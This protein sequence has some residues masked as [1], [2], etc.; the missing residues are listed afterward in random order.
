MACRTRG[1]IYQL[2]AKGVW[3]I[4][5]KAEGR[6]HR[7]RLIGTDGLPVANKKEAQAAANRLLVPIREEDKAERARLLMH[8]YRDAKEAAQSAEMELAN[9][10]GRVD[11]GWRMFMEC[12]RRPK[13]CRD[14]TAKDAVPMHS[15]AS[16]YK[17]IF[18]RFSK[19]CSGRGLVLLCNVSGEDA[20]AFMDEL[21]D[22]SNGT[23][24]K[25]RMFLHLFYQLLIDSGKIL[26]A[27]PF[28]DV[29]PRDG[30]YNSKE[31]LEPEQVSALIGAA[32]GEMKV[33]FML[34]YYTGLRM[35]DCCTLRW[36]EVKP[37]RGVIERLPNKTGRRSR[38]KSQA[39]VKVGIAP[40]L[41]DVLE[42]LP[43]NGEYVLPGLAKMYLAKKEYLVTNRVNRVFEQCGIATRVEGTGG[44]YGYDEQ[45]NRIYIKGECRAIVRYGFHSLRYS[46][47]SHNAEAGTPM[48]IIQRNAGHA[49]RMMTEHY[50]KISDAAARQYADALKL[51]EKKEDGAD[52]SW[53]KSCVALRERLLEMCRQLPEDR[54]EQAIVILGDAIAEN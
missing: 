54:L 28:A 15:T 3:Y 40:A 38:D 39:I 47:I 42:A 19:W 32:E 24:N 9:L 29:L 12:P 14:F 53:R 30:D 2:G 25:Y 1:H 26:C 49:S 51:P 31:P 44:R 36:V 16:N 22:V 17:A 11:N 37:A 50:L 52:E 27:N 48:G 43:R 21:G 6:E 20:V 41:L 10:R 5:Y 45:G 18:E 7:V 35:G 13:S 34:G 33:L 23:W 4:R 46:Y 8:D